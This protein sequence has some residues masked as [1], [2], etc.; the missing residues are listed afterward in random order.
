VKDTLC[1]VASH[2]L[3]RRFDFDRTDC[4]IWGFN[5]IMAQDWYKRADAVFQMHLEAIWR[6]PQNRNDPNHCAWLMSGDTPTVYM[7]DAHPD[8]PKS[9]KYPLDE[10]VSE[11]LPAFM[12]Q[13]VSGYSDNKYF[14]SSISYAVALGIYKGYKRIECWGME[15]NTDTEY[16]YQR[17][18]LTFWQGVAVGR[19]IEIAAYT[20]IYNSPLYGYEGEAS[21]E[22]DTF[23]TRLAQLR[24][25][26]PSKKAAYDEAREAANGAALAFIQNIDEADNVVESLKEQVLSAYEFGIIDGAMQENDRYRQ[27]ADAMKKAADNDFLFSR[28]EFEAGIHNNEKARAKAEQKAH[29]LAGACTELFNRA[30]TTKSSAR[31]RTIMKKLSSLGSQYIEASAYTGLFTGCKQ[32]NENYVRVLDKLIRAAGGAKSE[33]VLL[34]ENNA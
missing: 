5:E 15:M 22:Y 30:R 2:P 31:R 10:I 23:E 21:L 8:V 34:G 14:S 27:K 3:A 16:R 6:N 17:D 24:E 32:E 28:Q 12:W 1:I 20:E 29:S 7:L 18:G 4:D 26:M 19:G 25:E 33:A 9:E 11:L 13:S